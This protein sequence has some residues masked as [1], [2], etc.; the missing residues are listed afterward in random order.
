M[1]SQSAHAGCWPFMMRVSLVLGCRSHRWAATRC[2]AQFLRG[3]GTGAVWGSTLATPPR[4]LAQRGRRKCI[5][6][7]VHGRTPRCVGRHT[8]SLLAYDTPC[9]GG[10]SIVVSRGVGEGE[11]EGEG[12]GSVGVGCS[13]RGR[14]RGSVVVD[15]SQWARA[16]ARAGGEGQGEGDGG[17]GGRSQRAGARVRVGF[18]C[19]RSVA[20]GEGEGSLGLVAA[21]WS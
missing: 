16:G 21:G 7:E 20:A 4:W 14:G 5:Y 6:H 8:C 10:G 19:S 9:A 12:E 17:G 2:C 11:G 3:G 18:G 15:R 13:G 1:L